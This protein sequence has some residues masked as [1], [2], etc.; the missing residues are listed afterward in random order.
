MNEVSIYFVYISPHNT[1]GF[2]NGI[3]DK[4][5]DGYTR[6][7]SNGLEHGLLPCLG[8]ILQKLRIFLFAVIDSGVE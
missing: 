3:L 2:F 4:L 6:G 1:G 5:V 8:Y 7:Q